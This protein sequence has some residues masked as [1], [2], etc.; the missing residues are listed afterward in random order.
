MLESP[1]SFTELV[2]EESSKA[3]RQDSEKRAFLSAFIRMNG[4]LQ[5]RDNKNGLEVTSENSAIAKVV[6]HYL[7]D[8]YG[9]R[10]RFAYTRSAGFLK[11]IVYHVIVDENADDILSDLEVDFFFPIDPKNVISTSDQLSSFFAG[12]FLAGGSVNS[13]NSSSYHLEISCKEEGFAKFLL[14]QIQKYP[15]HPFHAKLALRRNKYV[16]YLKRSDEISDFLILLGAKENCLKFEDVRVSR[17]FASIGNRLAN[18]DSANYQK[19]QK[20]GERQI[21]EINFFV[22][23]L[24]W[25]G[26]EN[27]KLKALMRLRLDHPDATLEELARMLSEELNTTISKSNVNHLFRNLESQYRKANKNA[28]ERKR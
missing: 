13:P 23:K 8:L 22:A 21:E 19:S 6:Y 4:Y 10:A 1:I 14:K 11:R 9:I 26:I 16:V 28:D 7:N 12:A 25:N 15:P 18:L 2:K 5:L 17:D 20:T 27:P 3:D 24:G